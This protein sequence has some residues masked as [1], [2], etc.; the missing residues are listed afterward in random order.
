LR[1]ATDADRPF[2]LAVYAGTRAEELA[3]VDDWDDAQ[4][5]AF[6][7]QQ[8]AAQ[9]AYYREHYVGA[10]YLVVEV[11]G[12]PAGRLYVDQW[13]DEI[14]L[15]DISLLP[16]ARGRG[17]GGRVLRDLQAEATR[18]A[19]PLRIHVERYNPALALYERLGFRLLEERGVYLFL[20]WRPGVPGAP[21]PV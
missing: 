19:K 8:F 5:A 4:K 15:M 1:A 3:L 20:E 7:A 16:A 2:L 17:V 21:T 11:D 18:C 14:R 9:D 6:V 10:H 12:V 13:Q